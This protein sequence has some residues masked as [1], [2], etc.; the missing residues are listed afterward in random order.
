[1]GLFW[2]AN[3][4]K[5]IHAKLKGLQNLVKVW[6]KEKFGNIDGKIEVLEQKQKVADDTNLDCTI[7]AEIKSK[8]EDLVRLKSSMLCQQSRLNWQL[9]GEKNTRFFHRAI[10]RRKKSNSILSLNTSQ[11]WISK[12]TEIKKELLLHFQKLLGEQPKS[13]VFNIPNNLLNKL[14]PEMKDRLS[15]N[16]DIN[17]VEEAL[18]AS[19]SNKAP[20]PDGLNVGVLKSMWKYIQKDFMEFFSEFNSNRVIPR[21]INSSFMALIPKS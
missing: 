19:D 5:S 21:G 13:R 16:F 8:L 18:K 12:P 3:H 15:M 2:E 17:E 20:G 11:G 10:S 1:M 7:K 9:R 6:N 4:S 14:L